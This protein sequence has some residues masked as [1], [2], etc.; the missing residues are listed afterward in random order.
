MIAHVVRRGGDNDHPPATHSGQKR[1]SCRWSLSQDGTVV[2]C[3]SSR[4]FV[5]SMIKTWAE[6]TRETSTF[7]TM[8]RS[9]TRCY[10]KKQGNKTSTTCAHSK[11]SCKD[12]YNTRKRAQERTREN[13]PFHEL[14]K[15]PSS[16][17]RPQR[18]IRTAGDKNEDLA[19]HSEADQT[20]S[21]KH[22]KMFK[23]HDCIVVRYPVAT[24]VRHSFDAK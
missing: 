3:R 2:V 23:R 11:R 22:T 4:K 5:G 24:S 8:G 13:H 20:Q 1:Q 18:P 7:S 21:L 12:G 10:Q 9:T 16:Y 6:L 17:S 19:H 15:S 14:P